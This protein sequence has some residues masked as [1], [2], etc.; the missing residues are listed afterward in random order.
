MGNEA[1]SII[2]IRRRKERV[3]R[4]DRD[5]ISV[6]GRKV[7]RAPWE[8][9]IAGHIDVYD[10]PP[11]ASRKPV[12]LSESAEVSFHLSELAAITKDESLANLFAYVAA[13]LQ[14]AKPAIS[15]KI[16]SR[17]ARIAISRVREGQTSIS[18]ISLAA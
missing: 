18:P 7:R 1:G 2:Q 12:F 3:H 8:K 11:C 16:L 5:L 15:H 17:F 4:E 14:E 10:Q 13:E 6:M 9:F